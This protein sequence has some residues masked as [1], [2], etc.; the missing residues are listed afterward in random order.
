MIKQI[1]AFLAFIP[2]ISAHAAVSPDVIALAKRCSPD[3]SPLTMAYIVNQESGN[4]PYVI[5]INGAA[6]LKKQPVSE[7][8]AASIA[9]SLIKGGQNIDMGLA[10]IN[11][12]NLGPLHLDAQDIFNPCV[13][14]AAS[15]SILKACYHKSLK[16]WQPGQ[17]ALQ[18]ALSCYN[19][20]SLQKGI[21]NGY[22]TKLQKVA[23]LS[24]IKVPTLLP[25]GREKS[26][27]KE[28]KPSYDGENDAFGADDDNDAF[29]QQNS[30]AF[31]T[32]PVVSVGGKGNE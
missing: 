31:L 22:V 8:E 5:N 23:D 12:A 11:S 14:L 6:K 24:D 19:T 18:H 15:Q 10:Q 20:G 7:A 32:K 13:N 26:A 4:N 2:A 27:V 1:A 3:V 30:D 28:Q 25:E 17:V 29:A 21:S 16:S 9:N